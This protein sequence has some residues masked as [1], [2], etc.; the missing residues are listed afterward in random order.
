MKFAS[1]WR[2]SRLEHLWPLWFCCMSYNYTIQSTIFRSFS[3]VKKNLIRYQK[4]TY[5][6]MLSI[7]KQTWFKST[8]VCKL[9]VNESVHRDTA[10]KITN[11]MHFFLWH[12]DPT[13]VMASSFLRFLDHTHNDAPQSVGLLWTSNQ[14][15]AETSTWQHPTLTKN[16][17]LCPRWDSK[18]RSQQASGRRPTP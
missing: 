17:H 7:S 3:Q 6:F 8:D 15:V 18:P 14:L 2:L 9:D 11:E 16:K 1:T 12:C 13:L 4:V 5:V 10:M